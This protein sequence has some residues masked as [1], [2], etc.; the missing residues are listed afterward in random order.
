MHMFAGTSR[1]RLIATWTVVFMS[2]HVCL[3][4]LIALVVVGAFGPPDL[5]C[6]LLYTVLD[7]PL[8]AI[9]ALGSVPGGLLGDIVGSPRNL[10]L[11]GTAFWGAVGALCGLVHSR[12]YDWAYHRWQG[13]DGRFLRR[14]SS[15]ADRSAE[16]GKV[17]SADQSRTGR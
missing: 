9:D 5:E 6:G 10:L 4:W 8:F 3:W 16:P 2:V 11:V 13:R 14:G 17:R 12:L 7:Y 1:R 15:P